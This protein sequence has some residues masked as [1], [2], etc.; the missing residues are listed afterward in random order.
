MNFNLFGS[1][2]QHERQ[3]QASDSPLPRYS[4]AP[5]SAHQFSQYKK[6]FIVHRYN[7]LASHLFSDLIML[8]P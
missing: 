3:Y 8:D 1:Y 5:F 6:F 4:E 2:K 7:L